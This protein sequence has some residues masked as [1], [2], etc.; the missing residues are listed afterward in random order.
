MCIISLDRFKCI[1]DPLSIRDRSKCSVALRITSVWAFAICISSPLAFLAI[2]RPAEILNSKPFCIISNPNFL[3][4]G[5]IA[6][7]F[8]PLIVMLITYSLTINLLRKK[9]SENETSGGLRR[10]V[11]TKKLQP[12]NRLENRGSRSSNKVDSLCDLKSTKNLSKYSSLKCSSSPQIYKKDKKYSSLTNNPCNKTTFHTNN[13]FI[14]YYQIQTKTPMRDNKGVITNYSAVNLYNKNTRTD[15]DNKQEQMENPLPLSGDLT[16]ENT[17][18]NRELQSTLSHKTHGDLVVVKQ[19]T[20]HGVCVLENICRKTSLSDSMNDCGSLSEKNKDKTQ[21]SKKSGA[22]NGYETINL[23]DISKTQNN[24]DSFSHNNAIQ[25]IKKLFVTSE[26]KSNFKM[27][28]KQITT[29]KVVTQNDLFD[30][31]DKNC[32][33]HFNKVPAKLELHL[34]DM[35]KFQR[36]EINQ[37]TELKSENVEKKSF[38]NSDGLSIDKKKKKSLKQNHK[39]KLKRQNKV[40]DVEESSKTKCDIPPS[41]SKRKSSLK[42]MIKQQQEAIHNMIKKYEFK[43]SVE[44]VKAEASLN[45]TCYHDDKMHQKSHQGVYKN[46]SIPNPKIKILDFSTPQI[47]KDS[48]SDRPSYS[49]DRQNRASPNL[50]DNF[51]KQDEKGFFKQISLRK[52]KRKKLQQMQKQYSNSK[53]VTNER[54]A[55][56]VLGLMFAMF[57]ACWF[58]FFCVNFAMG[59]CPECNIDETFFKYV[60]WLGYTSSLINPI[61]YTVFNLSFRNAFIR[62]LTCQHCFFFRN[63]RRKYDQQFLKYN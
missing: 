63:R 10:T 61:I 20:E 23:Q 38:K 46:N 24:Y 19:H 7:F 32:L 48:F 35:K 34:K 43:S 6:A 25:S 31:K 60:L 51:F 59:V 27:P 50:N 40:D 36:H 53:S 8:L 33:P 44:S 14:C 56:K 42:E 62:I 49:S 30:L 41:T 1:R 54:K 17:A 12:Q 15:K 16:R 26:F 37:K 9:A 3:V 39:Q 58:A 55:V 21:S 13:K 47:T 11:S 45:H 57:V 4:Y 22:K 52:K 18:I 2:F 5:S 29:H 28:A